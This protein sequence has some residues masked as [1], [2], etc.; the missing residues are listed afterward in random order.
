MNS[1]TEVKVP[2]GRLVATPNAVETLQPEDIQ[3][4]LRRHVTGDWGDLDEH[5]KLANEEALLRGDR[6]FSAYHSETGV[7]FYVITEWDRSVTTVLLPEDY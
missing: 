5:D 2:L 7:K 3:A 6:L 4:A 1:D